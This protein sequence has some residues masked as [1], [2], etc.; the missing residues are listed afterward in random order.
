MLYLT[1]LVLMSYIIITNNKLLVETGEWRLLVF[2]DYAAPNYKILKTC[3][4]RIKV[5]CAQMV[6]GC[7]TVY[8]LS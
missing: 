7:L 2:H 3:K 6:V 1:T 5:P 8:L 4:V